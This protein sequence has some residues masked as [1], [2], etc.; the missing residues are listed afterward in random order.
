ME[1]IESDTGTDSEQTLRKSVRRKLIISV[2]MLFAYPL[3]PIVLLLLPHSVPLSA[4]IF[5]VMGFLVIGLFGATACLYYWVGR[6]TLIRGID[7]LCRIA[8]PKPFIKGKIAILNKDP[9]Y[10]IAKWWSNALFFIAFKES[11]RFFERNV[12]LPR[13]IGRWEYT[14]PIGDIR[15]AKREDEFRIPVDEDTF[16]RG[17]GILYAVLLEERFIVPFRKSYTAE[18]LNHIVSS[19]EQEIYKSSSQ[20]SDYDFE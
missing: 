7:I 11:E 20:L 16:Y 15:V 3:L 4:V 18:Q 14:H 8:P 6:S 17:R 13:M 5:I 9:V 19:L 2:I 1:E 12:K 10:G